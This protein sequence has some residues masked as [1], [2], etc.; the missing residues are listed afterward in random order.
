RLSAYAG[1]R[2]DLLRRLVPPLRA[3]LAASGAERVYREIETPLTPVLLKMEETG[4]LLDVPYLGAMSAEMASELARLEGE[5][6]ELAG[7]RF[8]IQSPTQLG[9]ILFE[10]L[11]LKAKRRTQKTKSWST[12]ADTLAE[13]AAE[14][15]ALP[16]RLL[17]YRELSKLKGTYVDALPTMVGADGRIHT[18]FMQAVAASGRISSWNPNLQ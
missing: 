3:E 18:R 8:N 9:A 10:K 15:H 16:E 17:R 13:L 4:I 12:D 5:I 6:Y 2:V 11:G 7:E 1:E 14:G